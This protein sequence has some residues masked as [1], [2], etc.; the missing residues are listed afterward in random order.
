[1]YAAFR[2]FYLAVSS[3][4]AT[5]LLQFNYSFHRHLTVSKNDTSHWACPKCDR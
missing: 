5:N 1:M 4:I 3:F 2:A